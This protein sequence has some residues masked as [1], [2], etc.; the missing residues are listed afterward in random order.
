[1]LSEFLVFPGILHIMIKYDLLKTCLAEP[2]QF[3]QPVKQQG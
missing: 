3:K 1:M 2:P